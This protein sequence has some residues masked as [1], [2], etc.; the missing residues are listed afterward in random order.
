MKKIVSSSIF[1]SLVGLLDAAYLTWMKFTHHESACMGVGDCYT[2]NMSKY[3]TI[4]GIPIALLGFGAYLVILLAL[5]FEEKH[6]FLKEN[7]ALIVFG[8]SLVGVLYSAYLSYLEEF[9][10]HAWCPYCVISAI[11]IALIFFLSLPRLKT[12]E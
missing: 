10:L 2:V 12:E 9:V 6:P 7:A 5:L 1:L 11:D 4:H 3:S 8:V